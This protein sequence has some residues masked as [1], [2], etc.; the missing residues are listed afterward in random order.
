[1]RPGRPTPTVIDFDVSWQ[2]AVDAFDQLQRNALKGL[3]ASNVLRENAQITPSLLPFWTF[4]AIIS[5]EVKAV[6]GRRTDK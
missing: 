3:Q 2:Q 6:L 5:T 1:M 4:D